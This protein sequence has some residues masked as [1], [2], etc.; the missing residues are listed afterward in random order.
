MRSS[1]TS[2]ECQHRIDFRKDSA[3]PISILIDFGSMI[4]AMHPN[5][6]KKAWSFDTKDGRG[7]SKNGW[8]N[9][10]DLWDE[11]FLVANISLG[12]VLKMPFL[13]LSSADKTE[14][15]NCMKLHEDDVDTG[16]RLPC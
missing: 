3:G 1:P 15:E 5:L 10:R 6:A 11:I 12:V 13:T 4:N 9:S 14:D 7:W 16:E 8:P 2:N